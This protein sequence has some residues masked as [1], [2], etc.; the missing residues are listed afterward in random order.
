MQAL[1]TSLSTAVQ[2]TWA[3]ALVASL[4]WGIASVILSPCHLGTIPLIVGFVSQGADGTRRGQGVRMAVAFAVGMLLAIAVAGLLVVGAGIALAGISTY[5]NYFVAVVFLLAGLN[6]AGILPLPISGLNFSSFKGRG[7][8][9]AVFLGLVF[10]VGLSPCTFAFMAPILGVAL[11]TATKSPAFGYLL[12]LVFGIGHCA[13]MAIAGS[14]AELVQRYLDWNRGSRGL[15]VVKTACGVC[16]IV[17]S[18]YLI[19]VA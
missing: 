19:Y 13:V 10:G 7:V 17:A 12:L 15:K 11:G 2:G 16:L 14:S 6:L 18:S 9:A 8:G 1:L 5:T 3:L 4:L